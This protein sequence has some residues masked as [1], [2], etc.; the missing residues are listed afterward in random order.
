MISNKNKNKLD[1]SKFGRH[2]KE[3]GR[4]ELDL[5]STSTIDIDVCQLFS[6]IQ[7]SEVQFR[8]ESA[9]IHQ[10]TFSFGVEVPIKANKRETP[11]S[12]P[13]QYLRCS[14]GRLMLTHEAICLLQVKSFSSGVRLRPCTRR[15]L[16]AVVILVFL[17]A[18]TSYVVEYSFKGMR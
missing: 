9:K 6:E 18:G 7:T 17:A 2:R 13:C 11:F 4:W 16:T 14:W 10:T 3:N 8:D 12:S 15:F 1:L 5:V